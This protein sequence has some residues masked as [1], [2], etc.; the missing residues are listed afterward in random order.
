MT[1]STLT[2]EDPPQW[3]A[4]AGVTA[5]LAMFGAAQGLSYPLFTL[6]MQ[7]QGISPALIGLSAA[8]MP[9]G[10]ILSASFVPVA[11]RLFGARN[12][13][14]GCALA[15]ALCF[16]AIGYLQNW[17]AWFV[18]RFL[19][20]FAINPLYVLGEV[21]ALSLAPPSRRGR[22]M[23]VF[24]ALMG[25][26]YAAGP[27][28]LIAVGSRGWPPFI[29]ATAGFLL[30]ALILRAVSAK[31]T[32]FEDD[33]QPSGGVAGFARLAPA[34]LLAVLVSAA[35][36]QSTYSLIPVFGSGFGLPEARQA[37]LVTAL[38]LGNIILQIPLGLMAER[39]GGRAMIVFCALATASCAISLPL[40]IA[41]PFIW[42]VLVVMGAVG[43]GVYTMALIELG[44]RFKG[45]ILVAGNAAFA[46]MWGV[47]GIVGPPGAGALMQV[48]GP[49]GLPA[50]IV[51][52]DF[53]LV[54]FALYRSL[55]RRGS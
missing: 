47:G 46:L 21:W 4:L 12:L 54:A 15:G 3:A 7:R 34:L 28:I 14:V 39:F 40:L 42:P 50:V 35:V 49:L 25:A 41:T 43:Y 5:A 52:L 6:L 19:V 48:I 29:A 16:L 18:I 20:G 31:L 44:T 8:M 17:V 36:Q 53:L 27:L 33:G 10:L 26:G 11:V 51:G 24:N 37:A 45:T 55:Q 23:G 22:V 30:C 13:G 32:G 9:V 1:A 2:T 38:S